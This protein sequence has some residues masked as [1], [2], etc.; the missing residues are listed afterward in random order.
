MSSGYDAFENMQQRLQELQ[1]SQL[2]P[3]TPL[4]QQLYGPVTAS[5]QPVSIMPEP[6]IRSLTIREAHGGWIL[7]RSGF[8]AAYPELVFT[9]REK[10]IAAISEHFPER[11]KEGTR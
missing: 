4:M 8:P 6:K 7:I 11:S 10:L 3:A 1:R 9:D 5:Q 2:Q